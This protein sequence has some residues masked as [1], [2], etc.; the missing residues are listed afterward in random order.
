MCIRDREEYVGVKCMWNRGW[1]SSH[2]VTVGLLWVA[3]LSAIRCTCRSS[4]TWASIL[5]RNFLN[6]TARWRRWMLEITVP[7]AVL[8]A[9]NKLVGDQLVRGVQHRR[10]DR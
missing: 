4:G 7:S 5:V 2:L 3:E 6:S 9:A 8:N 1:A 10:R